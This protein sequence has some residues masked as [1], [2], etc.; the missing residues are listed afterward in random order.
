MSITVIEQ[1][2]ISVVIPY[3]EEATTQPEY[4][5][6]QQ[7]INKIAAYLD[8]STK[9]LDKRIKEIFQK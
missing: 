5:T 1:P 9:Y 8:D 3:K 7:A 6:N 4:L 2:T